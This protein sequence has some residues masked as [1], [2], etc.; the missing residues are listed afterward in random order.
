MCD[1]LFD[2]FNGYKGM[3]NIY[4][5]RKTDVFKTCRK[6]TFLGKKIWHKLT[7]EINW[8]YIRRSED[9]YNVLCTFN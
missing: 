5:L 7:Q 9:V 3:S 2:V 4:Y 8:T 1:L 6:S